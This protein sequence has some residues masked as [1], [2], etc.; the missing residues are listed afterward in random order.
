MQC[1]GG[2]VCV[3]TFARPSPAR[4]NR[5]GS[6]VQHAQGLFKQQSFKVRCE[7]SQ[8]AF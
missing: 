3:F 7:A 6:L 4:L 5:T 1:L 2:G 8:L